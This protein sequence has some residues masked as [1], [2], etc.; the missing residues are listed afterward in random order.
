M[1]VQP[2]LLFNG[3]CEEALDFYRDTLGVTIEMLMRFK[4]S[5]E[6]PSPDCA[7]VSGELVMH[8]SFRIGDSVLM[9]SDGQGNDAPDFK[10]FSLSLT[11]AD[12]DE[13]QRKFTALGEGG[14][15]VMPL[16]RTFFAPGFGMLVDRF[17]VSWMVLAMA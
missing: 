13:A 15:V 14:Q 7:P 3:R 5:P 8:A 1:L 11:T 12:V 2:Y 9:A 4:D 17:G 16:G 6:P 10:G